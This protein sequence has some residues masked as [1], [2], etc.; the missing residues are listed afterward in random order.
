MNIYNN[1]LFK[2]S[3]GTSAL[4]DTTGI[5]NETAAVDEL[6]NNL[7]ANASALDDLLIQ[8]AQF[9]EAA[10]E[11][12]IAAIFN[13]TERTALIVAAVGDN[14]VAIMAVWDAIGNN[15]D[16]QQV[17]LEAL[18]DLAVDILGLASLNASQSTLNPMLGFTLPENFTI[19]GD[20]LGLLGNLSDSLDLGGFGG[21]LGK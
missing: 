1:D 20:L 2:V 16:A 8:M 13:N 3:G 7:L 5:G 6:L 19:G 14:P 15:T 11:D 21:L 17:Y 10:L 9:E 12:F 4:N 18:G